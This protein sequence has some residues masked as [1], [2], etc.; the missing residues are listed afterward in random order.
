[1]AEVVETVD[2][3]EREG[4]GE[5]RPAKRP[6]TDQFAADLEE[7]V[8]RSL[9]APPAAPRPG[10]SH[11]GAPAPAPPRSPPPA[12]PQGGPD[13]E[14][15]YHELYRSHRRL[16]EALQGSLECPVCMETIRTAPVPC[17]RNGH[18]ICGVCVQ[19]TFLCPTCRAPMSLA[20][21]QRCVSHSAN[22]LID[23]L[24]HP[25]THRDSGC[26]VEELLAELVTH[27]AR[28]RYRQVRCP[29]HQCLVSCPL[30]T[31]EDHLTRHPGSAP[32]PPAAAAP[33]ATTRHF[34]LAPALP[35]EQ[36]AFRLR[37]LEP[38]RFRHAGHTLYLQN[39]ASRDAR[40]L[41]TFVQ[42]EATR[43]EC[44]R[45]SAT[46]SVASLNPYAVSGVRQ[47]VRP[48]PLDLHC[49]DD[50]PAIGEA[51]VLTERAVISVLTYDG[52]R[53]RYQFKVEVEVKEDEPEVVPQ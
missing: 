13:Y 5:G 26:P 9:R 31:L 15:Q 52:E 37:S 38:L 30:A 43:E 8:R 18:L 12:P 19:R 27:E 44:D 6:R 28:C 47:T 45:L 42:A 25:C 16:V 4:R 46:I 24:P 36:A 10:C 32:T 22:R 23:L 2:T 50:L 3:L 40:H 17:C 7:A 48:T 21:G 35:G 33:L 14:E 41:Y 39:I 51:V 20:S 49:W 1:M 53:K 11:W 34:P 29:H